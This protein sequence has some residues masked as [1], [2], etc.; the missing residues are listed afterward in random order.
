MTEPPVGGADARWKP[1]LNE[2][3]LG[4]V[5]FLTVVFIGFAALLYL[6]PG[7][8]LQVPELQPVLRVAKQDDFPLG[9]SRVVS[10]GARS[11][12][13]VHNAAAEYTALEGASPID[14]CMLYWDP[15]P[16]QV[17]SPCSDVVYDLHGNVVRGLTTV[18]LRRYSVFVQDGTVFV[19]ES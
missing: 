6:A 3:V 18:P 8:Y 16:M 2:Y 4:G 9:A 14:G 5:I 10:W 19:K 12:L 1:G 13:V 15:V 17:T 7:N 11:V